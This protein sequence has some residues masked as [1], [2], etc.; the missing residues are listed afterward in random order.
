MRRTTWSKAC[1]S[2]LRRTLILRVARLILRVA[3]LTPSRTPGNQTGL[4]IA[5][6]SF[7]LIIAL[8]A[9]LVIARRSFPC[10]DHICPFATRACR[11][12][13]ASR[14][15]AAPRRCLSAA[16]QSAVPPEQSAAPPSHRAPC[17]RVCCWEVSRVL[18]REPPA[19]AE[20]PGQDSD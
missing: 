15:V 16:S 19:A 1:D 14:R 18:L 5:R 2:E 10:D 4:V 11:A 7:P 6:R 3:R 9:P 12:G 13:A 17:T 20:C 8:I